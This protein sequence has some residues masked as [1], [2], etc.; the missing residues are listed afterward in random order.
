M[1]SCIVHLKM[2]AIDSDNSETITDRVLSV[3]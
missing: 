1:Y 3:S 2:R